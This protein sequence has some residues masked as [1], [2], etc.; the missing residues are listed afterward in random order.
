M[1]FTGKDIE[2][3]LKDYMKQRELLLK[4][5]KRND[6]MIMFL[7]PFVGKEKIEMNEFFEKLKAV[8]EK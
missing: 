5:L 1:T 4:D 7:L 2:V 8:A 3:L 6:E